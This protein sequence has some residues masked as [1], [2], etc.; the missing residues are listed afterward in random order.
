[1]SRIKYFGNR[2]GKNG[3]CRN[4]KHAR[5]MAESQLEREHHMSARAM[6]RYWEEPHARLYGPLSLTT[7]WLKWKAP[8]ALAQADAACG[9]SPGAMGSAAG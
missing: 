6:R 3:G 9:V 2:H 8:N 7:K 4:W 5:R 1:M